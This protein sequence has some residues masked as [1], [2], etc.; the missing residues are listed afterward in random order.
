MQKRN[1]SF[2]SLC[3]FTLI[4]LFGGESRVGAQKAMPMHAPTA[5]KEVFMDDYQN[6][7]I[8]PDDT[9]IIKY[10]RWGKKIAE[11]RLPYSN[12]LLSVDNPLAIFSFSETG[13]MLFLLDQNLTSL[14]P[15]SLQNFGGHI[16]SVYV[17][18][19]QYLWLLDASNKR[20]I[21][22]QYRDQKA[23][24]SFPVPYDV[25]L[26]NVVDFLVYNDQVFIL[27]NNVL[28]IFP[29]SFSHKIELSIQ[30]G[31]K[32]R[33]ENNKILVIEQSAISLYTS[34]QKLEPVFFQKN[35]TIV[36]KNSDHFLAQ[37][38]DKFYLYPIEK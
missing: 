25:S 33:K 5:M 30:S 11:I 10:D 13:Q 12:K 22:Y 31:K 1:R 36:E 15:I 38:D 4:F 16:Q 32:L 24:N 23:I 29:I 28:Q 14:P 3:F 27:K 37:I 19:L 20:L 26:M 9:T 8:A 34:K 7:Y 21:Q 2:L 6:V 17:E 18:D 35:S